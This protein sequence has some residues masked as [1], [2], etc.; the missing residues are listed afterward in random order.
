MFAHSTFWSRGVSARPHFCTPELDVSYWLLKRA[1]WIWW[2]LAWGSMQMYVRWPE[3]E[4]KDCHRY[5][6]L[7]SWTKHH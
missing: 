2:E 7:F 6:H 5:L 1:A 4:T 3:R